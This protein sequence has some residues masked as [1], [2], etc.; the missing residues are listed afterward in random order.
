MRVCFYIYSLA[1]GGAER[2][3]ATLASYWGRKGW[4]VTIIT[5]AGQDRDFYHVDDGV[6]RRA[7]CL[8]TRS[9]MPWQG[10]VNNVRRLWALRRVLRETQPDVAVAMMSTANV[11]LALAGLGKPVATVGSE[12]TYPPAAPLGRV[13]ETLRRR[14][15]P[16]LSALVAQTTEG[17]DWVKVNAPAPRVCVIPNPVQYPVASHEPRLTPSVVKAKTNCR[18]VLLSVGRLSHEKAFDRLIDAFA[19]ISDGYPDWALVVLGEGQERTALEA[20]VVSEGLHQRIRFPGAV[21]NIGEWFEAAD[22]YALTSRVEGFPN[23]LL[24]AMA[25]GVPSVAVDCMTGPREILRHEIDGLLVPQDDPEALVTALQRLLGDPALRARLSKQA[26]EVRGRYA[27]ARIA[28]QWEQL[29]DSLLSS[30]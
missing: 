20:R 4:D 2:V 8:E 5:L 11:T 6:S 1:S 10:V 29:F 23:T 28:E 16:R 15:Y 24:E 9:T 19:R 22:A 30:R 3:T 26:V 25:Y 18:Y 27:V 14:C 13:W 7:L 12:R 21:G 17:A